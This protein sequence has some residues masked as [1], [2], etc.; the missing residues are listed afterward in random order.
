M[1]LVD[2]GDAFLEAEPLQAG[3]EHAVVLQFAVQRNR[4]F[5]FHL[6]MALQMVLQVFAY[7]WRIHFRRDAVFPQMFGRAD[8]R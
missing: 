5:G 6:D 8:A 7:A 1:A 4:L 3:P 2:R